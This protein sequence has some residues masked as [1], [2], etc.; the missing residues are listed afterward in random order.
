[1][2]NGSWVIIKG[3]R[4]FFSLTPETSSDHGTAICLSLESDSRKNVLELVQV[5]AFP[6]SCEV[7]KNVFENA[8]SKIQKKSGDPED[9]PQY[10]FAGFEV[11]CDVNP[12]YNTQNIKFNGDGIYR[13]HKSVRL[14]DWEVLRS[15]I[16]GQGAVVKRSNL[17]QVLKGT[18][19]DDEQGSESDLDAAISRL[20]SYLGVNI[21]TMKKVGYSLAVE[22]TSRKKS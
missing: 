17:L 15:L 2:V 6:H 14:S 20:R 5:F 13:R 10:S 12:P 21:A 11:Y 3:V 19:Y 7:E 18:R 9:L 8:F 1:M 22:Q 4:V 16:A